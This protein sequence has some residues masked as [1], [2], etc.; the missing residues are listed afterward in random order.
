MK[1]EEFKVRLKQAGISMT[2]MARLLCMHRNSI[3]NYGIAG[4]VPAHLAVIAVLISDMNR[5]GIDFRASIQSVGL[6]RKRDRGN[7]F[8]R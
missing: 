3:T 5:A 4:H 8:V 2:E 1:Y 7:S 6:S